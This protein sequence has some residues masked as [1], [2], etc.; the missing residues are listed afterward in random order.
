M[1]VAIIIKVK[2]QHIIILVFRFNFQPPTSGCRDEGST[3]EANL[4]RDACTQTDV[5]S[6]D[7][8][9]QAGFHLLKRDSSCKHHQKFRKGKDRS[10]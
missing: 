8:Q 7:A 4:K 9:T 1:I 2:K 10:G 3:P 5:R 6:A